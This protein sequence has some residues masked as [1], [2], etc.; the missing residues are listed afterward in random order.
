MKAHWA[1]WISLLHDIV[2]SPYGNCFAWQQVLTLKCLRAE[3][4]LQWNAVTA[5]QQHCPY[6]ENVPALFVL[7]RKEMLYCK[8]TTNIPEENLGLANDRDVKVRIWRQNLNMTVGLFPSFS[9][10]SLCNKEE[11]VHIKSKKPEG[12]QPQHEWKPCM[13]PHCIE[14]GSVQSSSNT[15]VLAAL[16]LIPGLV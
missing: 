9:C 6:N 2:I 11:T 10:C 8:S 14:L 5:S 1:N 15:N 3:V 13:T 16:R 7:T 12:M 4:Q